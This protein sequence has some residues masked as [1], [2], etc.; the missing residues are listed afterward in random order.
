MIVTDRT[1]DALDPER[2]PLETIQKYK[3]I[4]RIEYVD[5]DVA[6]LGKGSP[7]E[8]AAFLKAC[9]AESEIEK[10][11]DT[12]APDSGVRP[13]LDQFMWATSNPQHIDPETDPNETAAHSLKTAFHLTAAKLAMQDGQHASAHKH[14][15]KALQN[16]VPV[17]GA[18]FARIP[19]ETDLHPRSEEED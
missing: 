8:I 7:S 11:I 18:V 17:H 15:D 4:N 9:G 3:W 5:D 1:E 13:S 19:P 2:I 12:L 6:G 14:L 16:F 10:V